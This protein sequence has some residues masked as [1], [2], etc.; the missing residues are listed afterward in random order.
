LILTTVFAAALSG[1]DSL[2]PKCPIPIGN[3]P[4]ILNTLPS[5][6]F[7]KY[8]PSLSRALKDCHK[9]AE[10]LIGWALPACG[11]LTSATGTLKVSFMPVGTHQFIL[12]TTPLGI[13]SDYEL[14]MFR[15]LSTPGATPSILFHGTSNDRLHSILASGLQICSGT[16]LQS[17]GAVHGK[18][19]YLAEEPSTSLAFASSAISWKNSKLGGMK[20]LLGCEVV[21]NQRD[22]HVVHG[23]HRIKDEGNVMVRY[24]FMVPGRAMA[25]PR[26]H[27]VPAMRS[28][29]CSLRAGTA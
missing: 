20:L 19:I 9:D 5:L 23:I 21:G 7:L 14:R 22:S 1:Y 13:E 4:T 27:V 25:P 29:L 11:F 28:A 15:F 6:D 3:I 24:V 8:A 17:N 18:G 12:A 2:L 10:K 26:Q 16:K